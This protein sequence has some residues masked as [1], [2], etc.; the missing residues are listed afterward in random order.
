MIVVTRIDRLARSVADLAAIVRERKQKNVSLRATE[1]PFD[2]STAAARC[3]MQMLSVFA[4]V[5]T[6]IRKERQMESISKAKAEG[7]HKGRPASIN[8]LPS[9]GRLSSNGSA[10]LNCISHL[11][12]GGTSTYHVWIG[13]E[14]WT[15]ELIISGCLFSQFDNWQPK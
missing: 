15:A 10:S 3:F 14:L 2:A 5:K 11:E 6:A 7:R 1:Q 4:E 13:L 8:G 12:I 9:L